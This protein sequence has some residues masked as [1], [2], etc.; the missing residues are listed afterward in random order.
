MSNVM[1]AVWLQLF[2]LSCC[3]TPHAGPSQT[4]AY[5]EV[6]WDD[7]IPLDWNPEKELEGIKWD[8]LS[9]AD[10]RAQQAMDRLRAVWDSAPAEKSLEGVKIKLAGFVVP[11]EYK[12]D[13]IREF[14]L[15]PYFGACIHTPPPPANQIVHVIASKLPAN[16]QTMDPFWV[17]GTLKLDH[18]VTDMGFSSY[19]M[20]AD[21]ITRYVLPPASP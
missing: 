7:L 16:F 10:P 8:E 6:S 9:D 13:E 17:S 3:M 1:R 14:L 20:V 18:S 5:R 4:A 15:V 21:S 11:L 2:L 12:G 19:Q